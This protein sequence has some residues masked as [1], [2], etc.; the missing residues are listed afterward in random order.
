MTYLSTARIARYA[1]SSEMMA[2]SHDAASLCLVI[3]GRYEERTRGRQTVHGPGHLLVCPAHETH[4]Q[5]FFGDGTLKVLLEPSAEG[6][7]YLAAHL[8][9]ADAPYF[10]GAEHAALALR[11]LAELRV[12]DAFSPAVLEGLTLEA[13][14]VLSRVS[15]ARADLTPAWVRAARDYLDERCPGLPRP[16]E[17]ARAVGREPVDLARAFRRAFGRGIGEYAREQ[18]VRRA[19]SML[20]SGARPIAEIAQ[21]CGFCDQAHLTRSFKA[22]LGTTPAAYRT[23]LH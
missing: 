21:D 7:D 9:V 6:L 10:Y 8:P 5:T 23:A 3:A 16:E 17:V 11:F 13:L 4:A 19:A 15:S 12:G 1:P 22:V 20:A 14:G 18:R 2:H